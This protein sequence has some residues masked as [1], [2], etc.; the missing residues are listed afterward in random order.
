MLRK[1]RGWDACRKTNNK[2]SGR[3]KVYNDGS[4]QPWGSEQ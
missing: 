2:V 3:R 4:F 1:L